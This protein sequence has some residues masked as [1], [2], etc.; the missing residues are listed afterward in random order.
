MRRAITLSNKINE[1]V[2]TVTRSRIFRWGTTNAFIT[3]YNLSSYANAH[4]ID[5]EQALSAEF[6]QSGR[7][8]W[9]IAIAGISGIAALSADLSV[10]G[11]QREAELNDRATASSSLNEVVSLERTIY[12]SLTNYDERPPS[13][14]DVSASLAELESLYAKY[15]LNGTKRRREIERLAC[16]K[17]RKTR[18]N[19]AR[20]HESWSQYEN[21]VAA[22]TAWFPDPAR[23]E[24]SR[25]VV[26][27]TAKK[28][29]TVETK[30]TID[31]L[32]G[33][34]FTLL[35][36]M[37]EERVRSEDETIA[38]LE[39]I[40]RTYDV[41]V[42]ALNRAR[43]L[44]TVNKAL[45]LELADAYGAAEE[46]GFEAA[47]RLFDAARPRLP[48]SQAVIDDAFD[49]ICLE[50]NACEQRLLEATE[51]SDSRARRNAAGVI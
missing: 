44:H 8:K 10:G 2:E 15:S 19:T 20:G 11:A 17:L 45:S 42:P 25:P 39:G 48:Y 14:D 7:G 30:K 33:T 5:V 12:D 50:S 41:V 51:G 23:K 26:Q 6:L 13:Q 22:L 47:K 4:G 31:D 49:R 38:A 1:Y 32:W 36:Q 29:L 27:K 16:K 3:L 43:H 9:S 46:S 40:A 35:R 34:P 24:T 37:A 28:Y 21:A 18:V